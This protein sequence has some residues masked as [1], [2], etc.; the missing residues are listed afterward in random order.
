MLTTCLRGFAFARLLG[1]H[2]LRSLPELLIRRSPPR[3]LTEAARTGLVPAPA[4]RSRGA[5]PHLL[6]SCTSRHQ[7]LFNCFVPLWHNFP[8]HHRLGSQVPWE[9]PNESHA[10]YTPDTAWPVSRFPPHLSRGSG[11]APVSMSSEYVSMPL[12]RFTC[13]RLSHP[14]LTRFL[15]RLFNHDVH[16][17]GLWP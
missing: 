3:L 11:G 6:R 17:R 13:A 7:F 9:S 2:L 16:H 10:F 1:T 14:Y 15:P 5:P 4:S 12:R 8:W